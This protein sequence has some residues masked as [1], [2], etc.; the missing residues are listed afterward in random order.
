MTLRFLML[1]SRKAT[2][3]FYTTWYNPLCNGHFKPKITRFRM[4]S[5]H[6]RRFSTRVTQSHAAYY[7]RKANCM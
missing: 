5:S 2:L 1:A 6:A 7:R 4:L 3:W